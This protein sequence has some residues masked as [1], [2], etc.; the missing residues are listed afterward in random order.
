MHSVPGQRFV[1]MEAKL[2]LAKV[3]SKFTIESTRP[4]NELKVTYEVI[5]KARGGLRVWL[6]RR[7]NVESALR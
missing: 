4:L 7:T 3:L 5:L 1:M 2:L 6:R